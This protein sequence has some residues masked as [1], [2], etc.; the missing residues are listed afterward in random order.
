MTL[1]DPSGV[2]VTKVNDRW[3]IQFTDA[4]LQRDEWEKVSKK[5][6]GRLQKLT[7]PPAPKGPTPAKEPKLPPPKKPLK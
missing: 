6:I 1:S 7:P 2:T 4:N 5:L 3:A